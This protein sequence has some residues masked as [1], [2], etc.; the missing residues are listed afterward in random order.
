MALDE[1]ATEGRGIDG[2]ALVFLPGERQI[3]ECRDLLVAHAC[4]RTGRC[5]RCSRG[6]PAQEQQRIFARSRPSPGGARDQCRGDLAHDPGRAVRR[7]QRTRAREPLQSALEVP[8]TADRARVTGE[9]GPA[10]GPLRARGRWNLHPALCRGRIYRATAL[11]GS[12]DPAYQPRE[13]DPADGGAR[14]RRPGG[15]LVP[16]RAGHAPVERRLSPAAG[17][18]RGGRRSAHHAA[19]PADGRPPGRPEARPR[20]ARGRAHRLPGRGAR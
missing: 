19:R 7:G 9:R 16:R 1:L 4:R 3:A 2:D 6:C 17:I 8:E 14:P 15:F 20:P 5:C 10:H 12:G 13:P 18:E 11:H